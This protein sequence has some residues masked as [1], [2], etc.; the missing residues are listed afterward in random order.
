MKRGIDFWWDHF[1]ANRMT[2]KQIKRWVKEGERENEWERERERENLVPNLKWIILIIWAELDLSAGCLKWII[3]IGILIEIYQEGQQ[4]GLISGGE[5]G[6]LSQTNEHTPP[7]VRVSP[8]STKQSIGLS[9]NANNLNGNYHDTNPSLN[10]SSHCELTNGI[11]WNTTTITTAAAAA[12]PSPPPP[13]PSHCRL[14]IFCLIAP[15]PLEWQGIYL[16]LTVYNDAHLL[17]C[18]FGCCCCIEMCSL[19]PSSCLS[20][21]PSSYVVIGGCYPT[22]DK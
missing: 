4:N 22:N 2:S 19:P 17:W 13:L 12:T 14:F 18:H 5:S 11:I 6:L 3:Q 7:P 9:P 15:C 20:L 16:I 21:S 8:T 10:A 1:H